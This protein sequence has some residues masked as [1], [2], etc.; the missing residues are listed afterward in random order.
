MF[1]IRKAQF[2]AFRV[3]I[4]QKKRDDI[5][6]TLEAVAGNKVHQERDKIVVE[7]QKGRVSI[8]HYSE[9]NLLAAFTK[10][11]GLHCKFEYDEDDR[12]SKVEFPGDEALQLTYSDDVPT[13]VILN[14]ATTELKYDSKK[15]ITE[16]V[17]PDKKGVNFQYNDISQAFSI[18]NRA[19]ASQSY[20]TIIE[21]NRL[22]Y[23]LEDALG[24]KT[25]LR[26]DSSGGVEKI[27][28]PD[29]S[30][31]E[32][33]YDEV[34]NAQ[35]VKLRNGT[36]R[37]TYFEDFYP[38]RTEW[39]DGNYLEISVN[40]AQLVEQIENQTGSIGYAFDEKQRLA[41][42]SFQQ[43]K[44]TYHYE[45]EVLKS[46]IYPSGLEVTYDYDEDDRLKSLTVGKQTCLFKYTSNGT[47]AEIHYPNG[48]IEYQVNKVL[49]GLQESRLVSQA[50]QVVSA[51]QYQYDNLGRVIRYEQNDQDARP[52][53]WM[54]EYDE[55]SRLTKLNERN[56]GYQE[57]YRYDLKGNIVQAG[58]NRVAVGLMDEVKSIGNK[59][60]AYDKGGN[61]QEFIDDEGRHL[62]L[63]YS[64]EGTLKQARVND[65]TWEYWYDGLGRR[66]GKSNGKE[67]YVF[68]WSGEKLLSEEH[69]LGDKTI[70][71]EYIY[72]DSNVPVA[73]KENDK[74]YWLQCDVRGSVTAVYDPDG[75]LVWKAIYTA[76][77]KAHITIA[78]IHQPWRLTGQYYD[79]ETS[80]HYNLARYY[81][82]YLRT[83]LSLDP[84]WYKYGANNYN[85]AANDPYNR[86]DSD[87]HFWHI[88]AG[89]VIGAVVGGVVSA[90]LAPEGQ[91]GKAFFHGAMQGAF[92]GALAFATGGAGILAGAAGFGIGEA[93]ANVIEGNGVCVGC[94]LDAFL[95]GLAGGLV[96]L[97]LGEAFIAARPFLRPAALWLYLAIAP[98]NKAL[99]K[100]GQQ[101]VR[102]GVMQLERSIYYGVAKEQAHKAA[103]EI[104]ESGRSKTKLP[105]AVSA[106]VDKRTGKVYIGESG[107]VKSPR[108]DIVPELKNKFPAESQEVHPPD[109]CAEVDAANEAMKDG[110]RYKDLEIETVKIDKRTGEV[111]D[112]EPCENCKVTFE[113]KF[114]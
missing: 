68:C 41:S 18:V 13:S 75:N 67:T 20:E 91:R 53:N 40:E 73:F 79:E 103:K 97:A 78:S 92:A 95:A 31:Y 6:F 102:A 3:P 54:L 43:S 63:S 51:Q 22:I 64:Q 27:T 47:L 30:T 113:D 14:G 55:E 61:V 11:S 16:V 9:K 106:A 112:F 71:R 39:E 104:L 89:G 88:V 1:V 60:V 10:P 76:F 65:E 2:E 26:M 83:F 105:R 77:G 107:R 98:M 114:K 36:E 50:G 81:S 7:D 86:I 29:N 56:T 110:A 90:C 35:V 49:G 37:T 33:N 101:A 94:V 25:T 111:T 100:G 109:N 15:R 23:L 12:I 84:Q 85:Y 58:Q 28:F 24:R 72:T 69:K 59:L 96:G 46:I 70:L 32:F 66:V 52:K 19:Q 42:E 45:E 93:L 62:Q 38:Y 80:L 21:D 44:V 17:Y 99:I 108:E 8:L 87:G 34:L 5:F 48:L 4:R 57:N 82:P 74:L